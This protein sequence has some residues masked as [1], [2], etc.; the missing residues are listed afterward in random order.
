MAKYMHHDIHWGYDV[1]LPGFVPLPETKVPDNGPD[2]PHAAWEEDAEVLSADAEVP[3]GFPRRRWLLLIGDVVLVCLAI[4]LSIGLRIGFERGVILHYAIEPACTL[5]LYPLALY[6]FDLY[7]VE[8]V[9]RSWDTTF[10]SAIAVALGAFLAVSAFYVIPLGPYGRGIMVIEAVFVWYFLNLWRWSY[11][12]I[13]Q[14]SGQKVPTLILG[15]GCCGRTIYRLLK[16]PLSPYEVKG[17][18]DDNPDKLSGARSPAVMGRSDQLP[19]VAARVGA[20]TVILAIP[21][22]RS[23]GLIRSIL[24]A[25]LK[26]LDVRDM[27]DV[28]E[29][30]T[31]RIPVRGIADQWL[32]FAQGFYL[33]RGDYMQRLKR[34]LDF[35]ASGLIL[36]FMS[37]VIG[38]VVLAI[39]LDS[40]GPVFYSQQRVGKDRQV[41]TIY[42]FRSMECTAETGGARWA[43]VGDPRVTRVGKLLRLTHIDELPQIW[44]I[45]RGD[46]SL[47]GPRPE[48]P[49]F[50]DILENQLPYYFVRHTV[51]PG[52][53]GW[54]Q[55][56]YRYG[57]SVED[58]HNKLEYDLYYVKNMSIFL[59]LRILLRTVGVVLL[60]DGAR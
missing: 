16:S 54:A 31:G 45:F 7:N 47:V 24:N 57:A 32:L 56:N 29:A 19:E 2:V 26:G 40:P 36:F 10:R 12:I 59:D 55:I 20:R 60:K 8:R 48:R 22:N 4:F 39:K 50:V 41:F 1:P 11:G 25:R 13:F 42:K 43:A 17:F 33:L 27:A 6:I 49:E 51:K 18:I 14:K 23:V 38:L 46:M 3:L 58:A 35:L 30:L 53:T 21:R 34:L 28:Y 44:N 9:F 52:L 15:A 5:I 37:P